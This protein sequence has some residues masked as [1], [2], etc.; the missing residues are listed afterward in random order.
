MTSEQLSID[1]TKPR[2]TVSTT[3]SFYTEHYRKT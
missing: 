3:P 1:M 2:A